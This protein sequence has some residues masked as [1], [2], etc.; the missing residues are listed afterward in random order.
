VLELTRSGADVRGVVSSHG[1]LDTPNPEAGNDPSR[2][3]AYNIVGRP[4]WFLEG[5]EDLF[6]RDIFITCREA[7]SPIR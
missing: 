3:A 4:T 1:N 6:Q 5:D 2:Y 7:P